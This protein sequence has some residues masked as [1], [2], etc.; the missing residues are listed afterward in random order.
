MCEIDSRSDP[1][2]SVALKPHSVVMLHS[3]E[4][5]LLQGRSRL[6]PVSD[7]AGSRC[8]A[9]VRVRVLGLDNPAPALE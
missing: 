4:L 2:A 1:T 6:L 5:I 3:L 9:A 7:W 8:V